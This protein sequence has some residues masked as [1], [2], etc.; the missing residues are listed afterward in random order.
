MLV[1][2]YTSRRC[3]KGLGRSIESTDKQHPKVLGVFLL[4]DVL[5]GHFWPKMES[6]KCR[7]S[8]FEWPASLESAL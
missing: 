2:Q 1:A 6:L 5:A 8:D 3:A 7:E 4:A